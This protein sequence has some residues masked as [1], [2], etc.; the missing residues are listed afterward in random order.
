MT[1]KP[2]LSGL[3]AL[4]PFSIFTAQMA[5]A[6]LSANLGMS[7]MYVKRG[8]KSSFNDSLVF[9]GGLDYQAPI[10]LYLGAFAYNRDTRETDNWLES[11]LYA[12]WAWGFQEWRIG[13]GIIHYEFDGPDQGYDEYTATLGWK[14]LRLSTF[15]RD[16]GKERYYDIEYNAQLW[17]NSG[18][19][20][21]LGV[22]DIEK[23]KADKKLRKHYNNYRF[24]Y[25]VAMQSNV[26]FSAQLNFT[27]EKERNFQDALSFQATLARRFSLF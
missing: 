9:Q 11:N 4:L 17:E 8:V 1:L 26:E 19:I 18:L 23:V 24:G 6:E 21:G 22:K 3:I 14:S 20:F 15:H 5:Q 27:E 7:N 16:D 13:A 12:G 25:V 10:G 2:I